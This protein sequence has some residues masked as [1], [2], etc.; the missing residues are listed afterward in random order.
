MVEG[1]PEFRKFREVVD[2][3]LPLRNQTLIKTLYLTAARVSEIVTKTPPWERIHGQ[4][5]PFGKYMD[6]A[7]RDFGKE[8]VFLLKIA[9]TKRRGKL[10]AKDF[11]MVALPC[12]PKYEPWTL[13]LMKY[14][15]NNK[16]SSFDLTRQRVGQI[17]KKELH[18]LDS[19]VN[20]N[21]LRTY[22]IAHLVEEYGFD[23]Y[24]LMAYLGMQIKTSPKL[25]ELNIIDTSPDSAWKRYF[26]KLL[27]PIYE[28]YE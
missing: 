25:T 2:H 8:K 1:I 24:D 28:L 21:K 20:P 5:K 14:R 16:R 19:N 10:K 13:D 3:I 6:D 17:V 11:R 12:Y 9:Q 26:P 27:K 22:R 18:M 15:V 23:Q 4:T 7:I